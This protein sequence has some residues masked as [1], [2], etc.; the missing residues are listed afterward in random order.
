MAEVI[1][2]SPLQNFSDR[3][4]NLN[5]SRPSCYLYFQMG[6][7]YE[8]PPQLKIDKKHK[9]C[10][11]TPSTLSK[12]HSSEQ[13]NTCGVVKQPAALRAM[14]SPATV[15]IKNQNNRKSFA[16]VPSCIVCWPFS[17]SGV[18]RKRL[19]DTLGASF[20]MGGKCLEVFSVLILLKLII[21][22]RRYRFE[23]TSQSLF[24]RNSKKVFMYF[25]Q[26]QTEQ[27]L[28]LDT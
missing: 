17:H 22:T 21:R 24:A 8:I 11:C 27:E 19:R 14:I 4:R 9:K 28:P 13:I 1:K 23:K 18:D 10:L 15:T 3:S 20:W 25:L 7:R 2:G 16:F 26:K 6:C 12:P 5:L